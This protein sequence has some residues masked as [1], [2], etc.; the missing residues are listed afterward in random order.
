MN[1]TQ[2]EIQQ[3]IL[4]DNLAMLSR[5]E[6]TEKQPG[7]MYIQ[8]LHGRKTVDEELEDW[9]YDGPCLGPIEWMHITYNNTL[10]I[11]FVG[12]TEPTDICLSEKDGLCLTTDFFYYNGSYYGDWEVVC[13]GDSDAKLPTNIVDVLGKFDDHSSFQT[14]ITITDE[15]WNTLFK[16]ITNHLNKNAPRDGA[17]YET[18]GN[19]YEFVKKFVT[20]KREGIA[21]RHLNRLTERFYRV[22]KGR[23]QNPENST[24]LGLAI[25]KHALQYHEAQLE[26]S[27]KTGRGSKFKCVFPARRTIKQSVGI[28][29]IH[30]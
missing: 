26:I 20:H 3:A 30:D 22:D 28:N 4:A 19:E 23:S 13:G 9:G 15:Q 29:R 11:Q 7:K 25:V 2:K 18:Y 10:N 14:H 24:G 27:S 5:H 16:P 1:D 21:A 12:E 6:I 17:M 8:L